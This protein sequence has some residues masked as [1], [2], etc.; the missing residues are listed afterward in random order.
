MK[1]TKRILCLATAAT[2]LLALCA[3]GNKNAKDDTTDNTTTTTTNVM[4]GNLDGE[5]VY[6]DGMFSEW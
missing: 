2:L 5:N 3:C 1:L 6:N 4:G